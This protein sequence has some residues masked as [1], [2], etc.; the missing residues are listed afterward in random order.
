MKL[1][2][3]IGLAALAL[4][5]V[6]TAQT[7]IGFE[8]ESEYKAIGVYD[9]WADSPFMTGELEGNCKVITNEQ[10]ILDADTGE[11]L[12][13]TGKML[14]FQRSRFGSN[15]YGARIDL[16][17]P[18]ELSP[19]A[20]YVHVYIYKEKAG[21]VMLTGLGKRPERAG[22]QETEQ[23]NEISTKT[24][25]AGTWYDAVF[26][27]TGAEG[28]EVNTL[29]VVPDCESTHDLS[30]DFVVYIDEI[31][32]NN[33][34]TPRIVYGYYPVNIDPT[35]VLSRTD[36]YTSAISFTSP[37]DGEQSLTVDQETSLL[38]YNEFLEESF[39]VKAGE[40]VTAS[41]TNTPGTWMHT[42]IYLDRG[43]DGAFSYQLN[44]DLSIPDGSD[45]MSFSYYEDVN[46]NLESASAGSDIQPPSFVIPSDLEPGYYRLRYKVDWNSIDPG[47]NVTDGNLITDNG[48]VIVDT[49]LNIHGDN[50]T[51]YRAAAADGVG[52][53]NGDILKA[54]GSDFTTAQIPFGEPYT[55]K[56]KPAPGFELAYVALRHGYNL[57][58]D[59]LLYGTPQ[60]EDVLLPAYLFQ[61]S[62][63]T[64]PASY[65]DGNIRLIPYFSATSG[66]SGE[67]TED[68]PTN[69]DKDTLNI[70]NTSNKLSRFVITGTEG[71]ATTVSILG[72]STKVYRDMTSKQVSIVP[73]DEISTNITYTGS[74]HMYLYIDYNQDGQFNVSLNSNGTPTYASELVAYTYYNGHNSAGEE[75]TEDVA[76]NTMP[77]FNISELLPPGVYRARFKAD[78]NNT[79]PAGQWSE[80]GTNNINDNGGYVVDFLINVH[81]E[82][83]DL[84]TYVTNGSVHNGTST[85]STTGLSETVPCFTA[86]SLRL[87]PITSDYTAD[88]I[89]IRHGHLDKEQYIHGNRQWSEYKRKYS[90]TFSIPKDSVNGDVVVIADFVADDDAEYKLVFSD[91]F[92]GEDGTL[93]DASKW[94][95]CN[96]LASAWNR[97]LSKTDE[98]HALTGFIEDGKFVARCLPNP[99][100][101]TDDVEMIS[102]GIMTSGLFNF[103]Y[104]KLEAR[105]RTNPY[106]GNFPAF[107]MMP[108]DNSAGWP[109]AGEI[110]IWEQI[111]DSDTSWHTIH[112][113]WANGTSSGSLCQGQSDNPTKTGSNS[114]TTNGNYHTFGL[115]WTDTKLVWYVDG[116]QVFSYAKLEDNE[117][118]L[119]LGQWPFDKPFYIIL[120]QSVGNGSWASAPDVAHTYETL[121][122]WV[123]VYQKSDTSSAIN[124]VSLTSDVDV[125]TTKGTIRVVAEK[126]TNVTVTDVSGRQLFSEKIQGNKRISVQTGVYIVN[127]KKVLVP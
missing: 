22:Q 8:D 49:R 33:S 14:A 2:K 67:V 99:Y 86:L 87:S 48:G 11:P 40:T 72:S 28:A 88:S 34:S 42:Y 30:E 91:E 114:S 77:S 10:T 112:S 39:K 1:K 19:T 60:Y 107:W 35:D 90:K 21:R 80:G 53:L 24:V 25:S 117:E 93:P 41:V 74:M 27:I 92:D 124:A 81:N 95:R 82:E 18:I 59:S 52:G 78:W 56:Y 58:G 118:A 121:F 51:I 7:T 36:R 62:L 26:A 89:T 5:L 57:D 108:Q 15:Q 66:G 23:F 4:P 16:N 75:V 54:D 127:G 73:G 97:F 110:D 63:L 65:V 38:V 85:T 96:R 126:A 102:G 17:E 55:I 105:I 6:A 44:D 20:Q 104:G 12:N 106:T 101:D 3:Y 98:E 64:I 9:S 120:N 43:Q 61:D 47:G 71:G 45:L 68:Y 119:E 50:V 125:T 29:V 46:S 76:A 83:H 31:E 69:F 84:K 70:T 113:R 115:E 94:V 123:R 116:K 32:V 103:T 111:D 100:Q 13:T 122:D 109:Y 79:D 37:T